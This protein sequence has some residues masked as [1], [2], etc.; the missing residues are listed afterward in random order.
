MKQILLTA[1]AIFAITNANLARAEGQPDNQAQPPHHGT[2]SVESRCYEN[3]GCEWTDSFRDG[4]GFI[5]NAAI[6]LVET[7]ACVN[8]DGS[9]T[10]LRNESPAEWACDYALCFGE[11][12]EEAKAACE[13]RLK[14]R[15]SLQG[16]CKTN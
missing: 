3:R 6:K 1:A 13:R 10:R 2:C 15:T 5:Y 8:L 9:I 16:L 11:T 4:S 7:Q 12:H 14:Q